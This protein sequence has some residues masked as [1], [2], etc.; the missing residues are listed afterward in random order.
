MS[1]EVAVFL[2][3]LLAGLSLLGFLIVLFTIIWRSMRQID[4]QM[5]EARAARG[6]LTVQKQDREQ[7]GDPVER[8]PLHTITTL[9]RS[10]GNTIVVNDDFASA[11]HA[12]IV[13]EDGHWWLEDQ[14]SRNGTRLNGANVNKRALLVDGDIIRIGNLSFQ[15]KLEADPALHSRSLE[16]ST[17]RQT[18]IKARK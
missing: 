3:R 14:Q 10:A 7:P 5:V 16:S 11:R 13:Q 1:F 4:R 18:E 6:Y 17:P 12:L 9:G 2:L 15:L 8:F